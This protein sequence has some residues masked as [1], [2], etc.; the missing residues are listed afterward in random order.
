M[1]IVLIGAG[2]V[3]FHLGLAFF[4][5]G[6]NVIQVFSRKKS[7]ALG[8]AKKIDSKYTTSL[9][10]INKNADLYI[11][12][13]HDDAIGEVT[14][15]LVQA[16]IKEKLIVHTSGATPQ[17]LLSSAKATRYGIFYPLQS[18]SL[19][20]YPNFTDIPICVDAK[21]NDD[22]LLLK[23]LAIK[24]SSKVYHVTDENRAILHVAAVFVNNFSNHL[25]HIGSKI[26]D[27]SALPFEIL[28]PLIIETVNKLNA[29]TPKEMQTGPAKRA[30]LDTINKHLEFLK[31]Y[32]EYSEVY[33]VMTKGIENQ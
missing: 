15:K 9:S 27:K 7:K 2:N 18:F 20:R 31:D 4:E 33:K 21:R 24:I 13:V 14:E 8:L 23:K 26:V 22:L 25:F 11:I 28:L 30:D 17:S 19:E 32:P 5:K 6:E 3:G 12:A 29:G 10:R 1:K 16:G